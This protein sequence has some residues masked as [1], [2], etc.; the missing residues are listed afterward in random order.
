MKALKKSLGF[1]VG[2]VFGAI[3]FATYS[4]FEAPLKPQGFPVI[5]KKGF[6]LAYDTRAKVP[7]WTHEHL[8]VE[9]LEKNYERKDF[10]FHEDTCIYQPHRSTLKDYQKSGFDRGHIVPAGDASFSKE[11][12][13]DTFCLSNICP[14][15]P[16]LN[17]GIWLSLERSIREIVKEEGSADVISGPLF[18]SSEKEGKRFVT[19]EVIGSNEVAVPTHF[20]K[21]IQTSKGM[22]AYV[23]PN[24]EETRDLESYR[25][26]IDRLEKISGIKFHQERFL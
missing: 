18:L 5:E 10:L 24:Q 12:L 17:R 15:N 2:A 8:T 16:K 20:F 21:V 3:S 22:W 1:C 11:S 13:D 14:Q 9:S 6:T 19:Y 23:I 25:F 7:F 26:P 4:H